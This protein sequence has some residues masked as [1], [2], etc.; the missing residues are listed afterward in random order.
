MVERFVGLDVSQR[1]T[2]VCI[3]DERGR[4][5]WR[6]KCATDPEVIE[7]VIRTRASGVAARLGVETGPLTPWLVRELRG[8]WQGFLRNPHTAAS[9]GATGPGNRRQRRG[10][11]P[12][13]LQSDPTSTQMTS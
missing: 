4:R 7:R 9:A 13:R 3:L 12:R 10:R 2:S 1:L 6:G 11:R 5:V 8:P